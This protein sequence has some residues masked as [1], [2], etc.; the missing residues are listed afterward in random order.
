MDQ[1]PKCSNELV[2]FKKKQIC[3]ND[4]CDYV[5]IA[6]EQHLAWH[7]R[8]SESEVLWEGSSFH[9]A[10]SVIAHEYW[11]LRELLKQGQIFGAMLQLK[12][13][14]EVLLKF[15]V[16]AAASLL[17]AK[18]ERSD[19][20]NKILISLMH[21][22][23]SL[24]D[25]QAIARTLRKNLS[26]RGTGL[27]T[28][29][30]D[31]FTT[32]EK[33]K[34]AHWRN[35]T[36]GHGALRFQEDAGF[37]KDFESKLA[38]IRSHLI[39]CLPV[40]KHLPFSAEGATTLLKG[41][42][43]ARELH[44]PENSR[45]WIEISGIRVGLYPFVVYR[46]GGIYFFDS[47]MPRG[48]E[49]YF[50]NYPDGN[51]LKMDDGAFNS[52]FS[53]LS[54]EQVIT[55]GGDSVEENT[56]LSLDEEMIQRLSSIDD[57]Q[58]PVYLTSWLQ[59]MLTEHPSGMFLLQMERGMGKTTFASA[60]DQLNMNKISLPGFTVRTYNINDAYNYK[61]EFFLSGITDA[62]RQETGGKLAIKGNIP[63]LG[64]SSEP[65]QI[66]ELL[67]FF[68]EKHGAYY[69]RERL[70]LVIDG[71]DEIPLHE[72]DT[73]LDF[74]LFQARDFSSG[75]Y[76]L[77][78]CRTRQEMSAKMES[79]I[80]KLRFS[81]TACFRREN[82]GY[83]QM[84]ESY[85]HRLMH[86]DARTSVQQILQRSE[87]R[88]L[89]LKTLK[90]MAKLGPERLAAIAGSEASLF[91]I[92]LEQL[93][94]S[95]GTKYFNRVLHLLCV[96]CTAFEPLT[97]KEFAYLVGEET[98]T[99]LLLA[100]L[101]D[102]RGFLKIDRSYRGNL[103][104]V[105]HAELKQEIEHSYSPMIRQ[106]IAGWMKQLPP[107]A[108]RIRQYE[109]AT[110]PEIRYTANIK[111]PQMRLMLRKQFHALQVKMESARKRGQEEDR[112]Q[113]EYSKL[114]KELRKLIELARKHSTTENMIFKDVLL[115]INHYDNVSL[116]RL[117][118]FIDLEDLLPFLCSDNLH[119]APELTFIKWYALTLE[120]VKE[121]SV[122]LSDGWIYRIVH[123]K[124]YV[125]TYLPEEYQHFSLLDF[126][127]LL[128]SL[129]VLLKGDR[130]IHLIHRANT[131]FLH[132]SSLFEH[133]LKLG[134]TRGR[135]EGIFLF[136]L[137]ELKADM[138]K[139]QE[140][141]SDSIS[142]YSGVISMIK[143]LTLDGPEVQ[144]YLYN[145]YISR[146]SC[147]ERIGNHFL[148][149]EDYEQALQ[150]YSQV[151]ETMGRNAPLKLTT[152]MNR[153]IIYM[154]LGE[155]EQAYA[156]FSLYIEGQQLLQRKRKHKPKLVE[157][158]LGT[159]YH[160]RGMLLYKMGD[161]RNA[162]NDFKQAIKWISKSNIQ[163]QG[164]VFRTNMI[165]MNS[166][167]KKIIGD[168]K[169]AIREARRFIELESEAYENGLS[170]KASSL[171]ESYY[172][173]GEDELRGR[174]YRRATHFLEQAL[175]F[176]Q[177]VGEAGQ[178]T[179]IHSRIAD[180]CE[181]LS[182]AY[183]HIRNYAEADKRL[184]LGIG[185]LQ[186]LVE[187]GNN[188][189]IIRFL[190]LLCKR[191]YT[192]NILKSFEEGVNEV[193]LGLNFYGRIYAEQRKGYAS[194]M[195]AL[196]L[197]HQADW[198]YQLDQYGEAVASGERFMRFLT[199]NSEVELGGQAADTWITMI[200]ASIDGKQ[201]EQAIGLS[202][203]AAATSREMG[204]HDNW[205]FDY[206]L[207]LYSGFACIKL[208]EEQEG[209]KRFLKSFTLLEMQEEN[210]RLYVDSVSFACSAIG[211]SR[212]PDWKITIIRRMQSI[213][214]GKVLP[215]SYQRTYQRLIGQCDAKADIV[216]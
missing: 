53:S 20:D 103:I 196:L 89:Y 68:R 117:P 149:R 21:K 169:S 122:C 37:Q 17:Y 150:A 57:F 142:T 83:R 49:T 136:Q 163:T 50:L 55:L 38:A 184:S 104:S 13:T 60:L 206:S 165:F 19:E 133:S 14:L 183:R 4:D 86:P 7:T 211:R 132:A 51:K 178:E 190:E 174:H 67:E 166:Q 72:Q 124:D 147:Y 30:G 26:I 182:D 98:Q 181:K 66:L 11:R 78:T 74:L 88:F 76:I 3:S 105:A 95:Y 139:E 159:A 48:T 202:N 35:E 25:W 65:A 97:V 203:R 171:A 116:G 42:E 161:E 23:L 204:I 6:E 18:T 22:P 189:S 44:L 112:Y 129:W 154:N 115:E 179:F 24:G 1:C 119:R 145:L 214:A 156:N 79:R 198:Y 188:A 170:Y 10:P 148:A 34:V 61:R 200:C 58:Q 28:I 212:M 64:L 152:Y 29:L 118:E 177:E 173:V 186:Q 209:L 2:M 93:K 63:F 110:P 210:E 187:A 39:H 99:F 46:Q 52:L 208:H 16:L 91:Q 87:N 128:L 151:D 94:F 47:Y 216:S 155:D 213:L 40:Y 15:P 138:L 160:Y 130:Q 195:Y 54:K 180:T 96:L 107:I 121:G 199:F 73:I 45:L 176:Y 205:F 70:L 167:A 8:L 102:M 141:Y 125:Q 43:Q 56:Y 114:E 9:E 120:L 75:V 111:Q 80:R 131:A 194:M 191:T 168:M 100:N 12:D 157:L 5:A 207:N 137:L 109:E 27:D 164:R 162:V 101:V 77:L 197:S 69:G 172:M 126:Q 123:L 92:Y 82:A 81:S 193:E 158:K 71:I 143:G 113:L 215:A 192:H 59:Q 185:L 31:I 134:E 90:E 106:I 33:G 108:D 127:Y 201:W 36:I 85:V 175:V 140:H 144:E 135:G 32:Y 41:A 153:G 84:L 146:A 62:F